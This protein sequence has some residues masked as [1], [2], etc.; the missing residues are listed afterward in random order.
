M[1]EWVTQES[2]RCL[3]RAADDNSDPAPDDSAREF[4]ATLADGLRADGPLLAPPFAGQSLLGWLRRH[5]RDG[6][7]VWSL[8]TADGERLEILIQSTAAV[9]QRLEGGIVPRAVT[10]KP[11]HDIRNR[12]NI[13][14]TNVELLSQ[15]TRH[16]GDAALTEPLARILRQIAPL[17]A[18][19]DEITAVAQAGSVVPCELADYLRQGVE[20]TA[21]SGSLIVDVN[22]GLAASATFC[23]AIARLVFEW[24]SHELVARGHARI[25]IA[26]TGDGNALRFT[27]D[28]IGDWVRSA[29]A[30]GSRGCDR[31][32]K[33]R[34]LGI[35]GGAWAGASG[36]AALV[37][38]PR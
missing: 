12:L 24:A 11:V 6:P 5:F 37:G 38:V 36:G 35:S 13:I 34:D 2:A 9:I 1:S 27:G 29:V 31:L 14:Q 17:C 25:G 20:R 26:D 3:I 28:G 19:I 4:L 21:W 16:S 33:F 18:M 10:A 22:S 23:E 30:G 32:A 15:S 8:C 7:A